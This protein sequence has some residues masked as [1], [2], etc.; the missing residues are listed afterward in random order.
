VVLG[1]DTV[2]VAGGQILGKPADAADSKRMLKMLSGAVHS[3]LTAVVLCKDGRQ[4]I[5]VAE[6]RVHLLPLTETEIGW[7]RNR[8]RKQ[9]G[10]LRVQGASGI[11]W[12][13]GSW[14]NVVGLPMATVY[15]LLKELG[16]VV[17]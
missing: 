16:E 8:R 4:V 12:I 5:D 15:R 3:V 6:T 2:V 11:D 14:S 9:S 7:R 17:S 13:E 10:R 1:A